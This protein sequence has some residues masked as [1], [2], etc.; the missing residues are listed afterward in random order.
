MTVA[1]CW[2]DHHPASPRTRHVCPCRFTTTQRH[3]KPAGS[4]QPVALPITGPSWAPRHRPVL[5]QTYVYRVSTT[6]YLGGGGCPIGHR[7]S[8]RLPRTWRTRIAGV[9][10]T[11]TLSAQPHL[12]QVRTASSHQCRCHLLTPHRTPH[13]Y[14]THL[15][16]HTS[17]TAVTTPA[18]LWPPC[19]SSSSAPPPP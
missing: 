17:N 12:V 16:Q 18:P 13:A 5:P 3:H 15:H 2:E 4:Q 6:L 11:S 7:N 10:R 14:N 8:P 1:V 9:Y 19:A